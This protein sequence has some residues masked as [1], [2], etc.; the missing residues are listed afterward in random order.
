MS[1][2]ERTGHKP[3]EDMRCVPSTSDVDI[4]SPATRTELSGSDRLGSMDFMESIDVEGFR[5]P[6]N[7]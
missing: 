5:E 6:I 3:C 2:D 4:I 7:F 1:L